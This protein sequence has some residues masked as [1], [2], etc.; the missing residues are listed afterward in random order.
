MRLWVMQTSGRLCTMAR[1]FQT[2]SWGVYLCS[3]SEENVTKNVGREIRPK[4]KLEYNT[5]K[6][7]TL[8]YVVTD[9]FVNEHDPCGTHMRIW[10][11]C[12][13]LDSDKS[14][15]TIM[16]LSHVTAHNS[17]TLLFKNILQSWTISYMIDEDIFYFIKLQLIIPVKIEYS[18]PYESMWMNSS[19]KH[20]KLIVLRSSC[21]IVVYI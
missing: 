7:W 8:I 6:F 16:S 12:R 3:Q 5:I 17:N 21:L 10:C 18:H 4:G 1:G 13:K 15:H 20:F 2:T 9:I 19:T 14:Q 11:A